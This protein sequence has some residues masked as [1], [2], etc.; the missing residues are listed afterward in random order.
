MKKDNEQERSKAMENGYQFEGNESPYT[1]GEDEMKVYEIQDHDIIA[2]DP[3][4]M[5]YA[6]KPALEP[7]Y[8]DWNGQI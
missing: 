2:K 4:V 5:K 6:T 8:C 7:V 3:F 1:I